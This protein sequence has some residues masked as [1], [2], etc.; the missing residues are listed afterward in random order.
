MRKGKLTT[1]DMEKAGI[2]RKF[3]A[4]VFTGILDSHDSHIFEF[5]I[6]ETLGGGWG[7][8]ILPTGI[9]EEV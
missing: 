6:P 1:A 4:S 2:I 7:S 3:F 9:D 8:K 5:H